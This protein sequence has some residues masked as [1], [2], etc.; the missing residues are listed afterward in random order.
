[1][2]KLWLAVLLV[3]GSTLTMADTIFVD[4]RT[5]EEYQQDHLTG[6]AHIPF[7]QIAEKIGQLQLQK[8]DQVVLYC[9]SGRR[10][11]IAADTLDGMGF[12]NIKNIKTLSSARAYR[13]ELLDKP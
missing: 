4:V 10:A 2:E 11:S 8:D 13:S 5:D 9:R 7:Q 3:L 12:T 6:A 1:M